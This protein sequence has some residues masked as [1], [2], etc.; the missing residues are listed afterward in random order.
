MKIVHVLGPILDGIRRD[1]G[2]GGIK[3]TTMCNKE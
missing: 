2:F 1:R 3:H